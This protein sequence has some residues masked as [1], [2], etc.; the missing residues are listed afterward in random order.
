MLSPLVQPLDIMSAPSVMLLII[1]CLPVLFGFASIVTS[2]ALD[3][4][5]LTV[6]GFIPAEIL[7]LCPLLLLLGFPL[8]LLPL[9]P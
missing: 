2:E 1:A 8:L 6:L 9:L 7:A 5:Y 4:I 3:I